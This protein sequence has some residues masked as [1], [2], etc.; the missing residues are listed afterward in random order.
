MHT[1]NYLLLAYG[2]SFG[3]FFCLSLLAKSQRAHRLILENGSLSGSPMLLLLHLG[4]ILVFG[5]APFWL[6]QAESFALYSSDTVLQPAPIVIFLLLAAMLGLSPRIAAKTYAAQSSFQ[7][8][9]KPS[10]GFIVLYFFI[11]V[12]FIVAYEWWFRG[13]LLAYTTILLSA[14]LAV[15]LNVA[16]YTLL[17][18]V[19]GK[20]E[21]L[22]C[23]PFGLLLCVLCL[24]QQ[25]AWP[26]ITLHLALTIPYELRFLKLIKTTNRIH[27][28]FNHR[29]SR[30]HRA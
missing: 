10:C 30:L 6:Y 13:F 11:R 2:A 17:H 16:L 4:G 26:A 5:V 19:N 14:P 7:Q 27:E 18:V 1:L 21:M 3:F 22:G 12:L 9:K 25:A 23:L 29:R 24:W 8:T 15:C 20:K 28:D